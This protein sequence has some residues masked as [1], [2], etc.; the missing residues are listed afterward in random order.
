V[1]G[2][3]CFPK[4]VVSAEGQGIVSHLGSRL[5]AGPGAAV[6]PSSRSGARV[7]AR[8][9]AWLPRPEASHDLAVVSCASRAQPALVI[10]I[11]TAP[12]TPFHRCGL[13]CG[14]SGRSSSCPSSRRTL[15]TALSPDG[16]RPR[17]GMR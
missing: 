3:A 10:D 9:R 11:D 7:A 4:I 6:G 13:P 5:L 2:I 16:D 15:R 17:S 12:T 1:Q 14:P 8:E